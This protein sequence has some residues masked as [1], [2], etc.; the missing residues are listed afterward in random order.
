MLKQPFIYPESLFESDRVQ[1]PA[2]TC[3]R[4][5]PRWEKRFA[6]WLRA[7]SL[8][9]FLPVMARRTQSHRKRRVSELPLFPGYVFV[10]GTHAKRDFTRSASVAY[11]LNPRSPQEARDVDDTLESVWRVLNEGRDVSPVHRFTPGER[12]EVLDGPMM[13]TRG[14]FVREGTNGKLVVWLDLLGV[15]VAAELDDA[16]LIE[17]VT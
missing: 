17:R 2:W 7:A 4:T 3:V 12:V 15:G 9:H 16:T 11:V 8:P 5:R 10:R 13:G 14:T 1:D 6:E